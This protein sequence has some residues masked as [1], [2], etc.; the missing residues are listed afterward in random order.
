MGELVS[1]GGG[2]CCW[3]LQAFLRDLLAKVLL[4]SSLLS[5]ARNDLI[6]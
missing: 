5:K 1:V 3:L 6:D 4:A 2:R